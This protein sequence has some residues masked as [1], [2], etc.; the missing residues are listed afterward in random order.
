MMAV[1]VLLRLPVLDYS[2]PPFQKSL[3]LHLYSSSWA[4]YSDVA[5]LYVRDH[6]W[7]HPVPY[8]DY[9]FE[10]PV[11]TGALVGVMSLVPGGLSAYFLATAAVLTA[12]LV[13]SL[14]M[15]RRIDGANPWIFA[16]SPAVALYG[17]TNWDTFAIALTVGA[18]LLF[19]RA[20]DLWAT[21]LIALATAA[22]LFPVLLLPFVILIQ[23]LEGRWRRALASA[24]LFVAVTLAVNLPVALQ[25]S[26]GGFV[27][28]RTWFYFY[29]HSKQRP[30]ELNLWHFVDRH[31][32]TH[33]VNNLSASLLIA[34]VVALLVG[35]AARFRVDRSRLIV[36]PAFA[37]ALAGAFF[38]NK[39][40]SPQYSLWI[41]A[42]LALVGVHP[43]IAVVF[44]GIDLVYDYAS[45]HVLQIGRGTQLHPFLHNVLFPSAFVRE[46]AILTIMG[47]IAWRLSGRAPPGSRFRKLAPAEAR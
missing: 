33:A 31:L 35:A 36:V 45:Y 9:K 23:I 41:V 1:G 5:S 7:D 21:V 11:L 27:V 42:L 16:L 38:V 46:T 40:Y 39:L 19:L 4:S 24:G 17:V 34:I 37:A 22:K 26:S 13:V 14:L 43:L 47:I 2:G 32:S 12:C 25:H 8:F 15:M 28:R 10:Y 18:V 6:L 44:G 20:R 29:K 3:N 30:A